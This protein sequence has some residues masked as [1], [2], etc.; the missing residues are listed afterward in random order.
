MYIC[1]NTS[2]IILTLRNISNAALSVFGYIE[3]HVI[4]YIQIRKK[5]HDSCRHS[6]L[7]RTVTIENSRSPIQYA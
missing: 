5:I 3:L 6:M 7:Y 2:R 4:Q 1:R